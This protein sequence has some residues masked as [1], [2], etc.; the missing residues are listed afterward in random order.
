MKKVENNPK[1]SM[2]LLDEIIEQEKKYQF[3]HFTQNDAMRL[4]DIMM[5]EAKKCGGPAC[6]AIYLNQ[7][8]VFQYLPEGTGPLN[9]KWMKRKID[10]VMTLRW[11]TMH[12]WCWQEK[13][14][15]IQR[16]GELYPEG[17]IFPCGGG[18]PINVKSSGVVG[19]IAVSGLGDQQE[20][21]FILEC[22]EKYQQ[23]GEIQE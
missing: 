6:F 21:E 7:C 11:S 9:E 15:G 16:T 2:N 4:A 13:Y 19:A 3:E 1:E 18:F 5:Q 17:E 23:K 20:H 8:I 10:T 22:L 12:F 14:P